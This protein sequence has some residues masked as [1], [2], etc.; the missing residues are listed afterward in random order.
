MPIGGLH[1]LKDV[2]DGSSTTLPVIIGVALP[3]LAGN[4]IQRAVSQ[5]FQAARFARGEPADESS[6]SRLI[7]SVFK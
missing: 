1:D 3:G 2:K 4:G 5:R 7:F 6:S